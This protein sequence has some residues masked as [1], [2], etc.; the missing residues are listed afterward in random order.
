VGSIL[1][2]SDQSARE[3]FATE[4]DRNFSVVASA[5]SGKTTAITQRVLSIARSA[6]AAQI[7]PH[8][9]VVT[10]ANRAADEMQQ[11][12][13]Q[14]LL[15][16][17]LG[18]EIQTAFNRAF[19]GTIHSFC[20]KLLTDYGYYLGLPAPLELLGD[21]D[22]DLWREFVQSQ[23]LI[24]HSLGETNRATLLRL[25]QARDLMELARRAKSAVLHAP[26]LPPCPTL[27]FSEVYAQ[28]DKGNDNISKS[29]AE[30]REWE[31][32]YLGDWEYL[33]WPVCFT[34]GNSKFSNLWAQQFSLLRQ[35][36]SDAA[37]YV[38]AEIQHDYR[39]FRL[40]RGLVTYGDQIAL[41]KELLQHPIAA[42]RIREENF[43]I[44]LDEAQ[45][46]EP[47]QFSV[48]LEAARPPHATGDWMKTRIDPPRPGYFCMVGDFQQSIY[49]DRA[50]LPYYRAV[51]ETLTADDCGKSLEFSVTFRLD[52]KQLAFVNETFREILNACDG[53]VPFVEL[54]PRPKILPG[55][56]IR[57]PL[58][59]SELLPK[60]KKLK[61]YQKARIEAEY[62]AT[63]IKKAGLKK[64]GADSWRE[65]AIL[66]PRKAWLQTMAAALRRVRLPVTIQSERDV[67]GDSPAYAWLTALL[68]IMTDPC[69]AYEIVGVL[70]EIFGASDHDL[71]VFSE[72]QEMRFRIDEV[73]TVAG[74][75]SSH[76]RALA[77]I[78]QHA[79]GPALF[80]AVA[81]IIDETQLRERLLLLPAT[82]FGDLT[83]ELDAL[84]AQAAEAEARG[85]ILAE[86]AEYL[87][88]EFTNARSVRF[89]ADD[90][91]I[92]LITSQ[93]AKGSEWQCVIVPFLGREMRPPYPPYPHF[94]KMPQTGERFIALGKEDKSK[95]LKD[96]I[97]R[98]QN[99]ELERLLYVA[100]T[101]ARRTLVFVLDQELFCSSKGELLKTAQLRRL[102]RGTDVYRG[103]FDE[104]STTIEVGDGSSANENLLS[105]SDMKIEV[106]TSREL[107]RAANHAAKFV[108]KFTPSAFDAEVPVEVRMNSR[109]GNLATL[110]GR[111]WHDFIQRVPWLMEAALWEKIFTSTLANSP[112]AARSKRE[113]K[114]FR[115]HIATLSDL[116]SNWTNRTP[117][118]RAEMPF[119]WRMDDQRCLEGIIDLAFFDPSD[120]QW[121][122]LD[123]KTNRVAPDKIETLRAQYRPQLAAYR[124][125]VNQMTGHEVAA[126]IYSTAN[127][128]F[129]RYEAEELD[130]EWTRLKKLPP[131]K[132]FDQ[133]SDA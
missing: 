34:S 50:D 102:L 105:K 119:L 88:D 87:R 4:L 131:D 124:K 104:W 79:E 6:N 132:L 70:R 92:Q 14:I 68:T 100:T 8:L 20:M 122:I 31:E 82:E 16:E 33:R 133:L 27:D 56:V 57:V 117:I 66:C 80:D 21:D 32:R 52:E 42:Q 54:H 101:R 49:R 97:E 5:G 13:R 103:E 25:M 78:R 62:L 40:E 47:V 99:Q 128:Q 123:W 26:E 93:K 2:P 12:A 9:V 24:G 89:S 69:N 113:W 48:L 90:N 110:Y 118:I 112:D 30:L 35:W 3:R 130:T 22:D 106:I 95:E 46:T 73:A 38:A 71:A 76:L 10:F 86:F 111:W 121:L 91:A 85:M 43:R 108:R 83:R 120:G 75:I 72:A 74:T 55:Q 37:T 94:V 115:E 45:D 15:E 23:T 17:N 63:W 51:H 29:Q 114:L 53:Q 96:A 58:V 41:A 1:K 126:A 18:T 36:I 107:K 61:D 116:A 84:L 129:L 59:A 44:I 98:E 127:G 81:L 7:L 65:V 77:E 125:V 67:K 64:L 39:D 19:F 60:E 28:S 109:G 11:R